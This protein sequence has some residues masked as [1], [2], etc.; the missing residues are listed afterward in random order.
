MTGLLLK[1]Y[2][3][4]KDINSKQGR[5]AVGRLS[6]V[7]GIF[8]N[9]LLALLKLFIGTVS[10]SISVTADAMNNLSDAS[11]SVV[12]LIGFKLAE[13]P[14]DP[15]HPYGHAR[16]EYLSGLLIAALIILIGFELAKSSV[17]KIINPT[18]VT[19]SIPFLIVL[20]FSILAKLWLSVFN[21]KLGK[22]IN[23]GTLL[24][25]SADSRNDVIST[26]AVLVA[27]LVEHFSGLKVDG[28][29]GLC[30]AIFILYS[31]VMIAKETISPLLGENTSPE[32]KRNI[33]EVVTKNEK[34]LGYHDLMV[35][36]YGPNQ[37]FASL[38][39]EMDVKEDPM[40]CHGIIDDLE[41][42]CYSLHNVNLVIH[43]D[44]IVTGDSRLDYLRNEMKN[45]LN[46]LDNHLSFH[47]FR[48]VDGSDYTNLIF[49]VALPFGLDERKVKEH[50]DNRLS[51]LGDKKYYTVIT[52]DNAEFNSE[53]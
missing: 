36:D 13:K 11:G 34:V 48:M 52:F 21:K 1:I 30:V 16:F 20:L 53:N 25:T 23:S 45:I 29:I 19:F 38:H 37:R 39:V 50:I 2:L 9:L 14:A 40:L 33:I 51:M 15:D 47:D 22:M 12:T 4:N 32:L 10:G 28:Y 46:D 43:Y 7:V 8:T 44:P 42:E 49:D 24:A 5:A 6:G 27:A 3:K 17:N 18:A 26:I 41:R 31:G 35:H